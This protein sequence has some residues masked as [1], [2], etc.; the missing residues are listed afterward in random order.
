MAKSHPKDKASREIVDLFYHQLIE[1]KQIYYIRQELFEDNSS[2]HLLEKTTP[3]F[4]GDLNTILINYY[5]LEIA[6]L[7]DPAKS[8]KDENLTIANLIES[9]D[10][11]GGCLNKLNKL[12]TTVLTFRDKIKDAR[13]KRLAHY[14]KTTVVS[15][16]TLGAFPEGEDKKALEALEQMC[17]I[18]YETSFGKTFGAVGLDQG[19]RYFK[20]TLAKAI[21]FDRIFEESKGKERTDLFKLKEDIMSEDA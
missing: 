16:K 7:T 18:M 21:A 14:D 12:N 17:N 9:I 8:G 4:F 10:W 5:L 20:R 11:P 3:G 6:K 19:V 15:E 13:N 1:L 2:P